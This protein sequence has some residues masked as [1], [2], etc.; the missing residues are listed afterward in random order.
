MKTSTPFAAGF[1]FVLLMNPVVTSADDTA[2]NAM[3]TSA[4]QT[5]VAQEQLR[6]QTKRVQDELAAL[7][8]EFS[9]NKT[10]V[11][12]VGQTRQ[13]LD[14]LGTLSDTEMLAV[15][16]ALREAGRPGDTG[17][18]LVTASTA[19]KNIQAA[20]RTLAD[21]LTTQKDEASMR[22]RLRMLAVRQTTAQLQN[23]K[24]AAKWHVPAVIAIA[25]AE[26]EGLKNEIHSVM[27]TL[28]KL[29]ASSLPS[30]KV[31]AAAVA[32]GNSARISESV[33][34]A[35]SETAL[36]N[37]AVAIPE[38]GQV[39]AA[40]QLMIQ[41]LNSSRTMEERVREMAN[42]MKELAGS[43]RQLA[44]STSQSNVGSRVAITKSQQQ[45][46]TELTLLQAEIQQMNQNAG[47]QAATTRQDLL[48]VDKL[49]ES[50]HAVLDKIEQKTGL[51]Q[52]QTKAADNIGVIGDLLQ[53]Q[54]NALAKANSTGSG[55][56]AQDPALTKIQEATKKIMDAKTQIALAG[57]NL[58]A[59]GASELSNSQLESAK[60]DLADAQ[61]DAAAAGSA[62]PKD[63]G[64]NLEGAQ[65]SASDAQEKGKADRMQGLD[66]GKG[67]LKKADK[68]LAGLAEAAGALMAAKGGMPPAGHGTLPGQ[69][70]GTGPLNGG[71]GNPNNG[72][73]LF[74]DIS[75]TAGISPEERAAMS[76]LQREKAPQEY[77]EMARQYLKNLADGELPG[78]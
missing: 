29:S 7:L 5:S 55:T 38:Q 24:L 34:K 31:F 17:A 19:Q 11:V 42:K 10:A 15:V 32:S 48:A 63:V 41:Q 49:L 68:A 66:A 57:S 45:F 37:Y 43:Q 16:K 39:I 8:Q 51:V 62:V 18:S 30:A 73:A 75:A 67:A 14:K 71:T 69:A 27:E 53:E 20:L 1:A 12:E 13:A 77:S 50:S 28:Q 9:E 58:V 76:L 60:A 21:R 72:G 33:D 35:A 54:A 64:E 44:T 36:K 46:S 3:K 52:Q 56:G 2:A 22:Q 47:A 74:T 25:I 59:N 65:D 6:G 23:E 70:K 40:L 78:E 26:Q 4:Y 61:A